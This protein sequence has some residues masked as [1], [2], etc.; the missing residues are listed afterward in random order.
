[1]AVQ[2]L[3]FI[4]WTILA[5]HVDANGAR[6]ERG[7]KILSGC[8]LKILEVYFSYFPIKHRL[9]RKYEMNY[10]CIEFLLKY[11]LKVRSARELKKELNS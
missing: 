3:F 5:S 10:S 2:A 6:P 9:E 7:K 4:A 11:A 1:M 8:L